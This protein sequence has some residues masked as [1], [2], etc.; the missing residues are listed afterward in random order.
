MKRIDVH[1]HIGVWPFPGPAGDPVERLLRLCD[2]EDVE[3][4]VCSSGLALYYDMGEGNAE[5][6]AAAA[7]D[8]RLLGYVYVNANWI[9]R[10]VAE[11]ERYLGSEQFV[12]VKIH[13][14]FSAVPENSPRMADLIAAVAEYSRVLLMHTVDRNSIRQM[15]RYAQEHPEL[16]IILAHA[17][18]TDSDEAARVAREHPGVYL[19]FASEWPGAGRIERALDICGP[20]QIV[21]G[22][23][24]DLLDPGY[25]RGMFEA[26]ALSERQARLVYHENAARILGL[27]EE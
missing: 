25:T 11:M 15:G 22:T 23:D 14:R 26:A 5:L 9:E 6:A 2:R 7:T 18:N 12:G 8:D 3:Y 20:E 13:P 17:A 24:M 1:A 10:S 4:A 27:A 21:Y 19:D 16:S